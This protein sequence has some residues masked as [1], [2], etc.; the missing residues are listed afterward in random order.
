MIDRKDPA[1]IGRDRF[2]LSAGHAS[3]LLYSTLHLAG[4]K[5]LDHHGRKTGK[6]A[7]NLST[8]PLC[9]LTHATSADL[10]ADAPAIA[11]VGTHVE[12]GPRER[13]RSVIGYRRGGRTIRAEIGREHGGSRRFSTPNASRQT[14]R[15]GF[16]LGGRSLHGAANA[17]VRT[18]A[19]RRSDRRA[20]DPGALSCSKGWEFA[21][22]SAW[23]AD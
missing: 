10:V 22:F 16:S 8:A 3:M 21:A 18:A 5:E 23:C 1:W 11:D 17:I 15:V 13:R 2:V 19:P 7:V 12:A 9:I 4:V 20:M 6:L 14:G